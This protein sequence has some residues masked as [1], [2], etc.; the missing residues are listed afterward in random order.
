M[1]ILFKTALTVNL[2]LPMIQILQGILKLWFVGRILYLMRRALFAQKGKFT[3]SAS[4][5]TGLKRY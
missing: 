2:N 3:I 1:E 5:R 4:N